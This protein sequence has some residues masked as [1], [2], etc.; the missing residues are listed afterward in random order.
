MSATPASTLCSMF[1]HAVTSAPDK[2]AIRHLGAALTY[3]EL[4]LA[5]AALAHPAKW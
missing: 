2:V 3:R 1:D 4:G 5:V